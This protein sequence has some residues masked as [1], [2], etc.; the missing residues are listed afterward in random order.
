LITSL[1]QALSRLPRADQIQT[2]AD[3]TVAAITPTLACAVQTTLG[4]PELCLQGRV[5]WAAVDAIGETATLHMDGSVTGSGA[6]VEVPHCE[7]IAF[8]KWPDGPTGMDGDLARAVLDVSPFGTP[9]VH[10]QSVVAMNARGAA[11]VRRGTA[12]PTGWACPVAL[13]K[14]AALAS[15]V[16]WARGAARGPGWMAVA[17]IPV[18][19]PVPELEAPPPVAWID[20][21]L[22]ARAVALVVAT[23][24]VDEPIVT[25]TNRRLF[26]PWASIEIDTIGDV[27]NVTVGAKAMAMGLRSLDAGPCGLS[28]DRS[29]LYLCSDRFLCLAARVYP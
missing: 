18:A 29:G 8:P 26:T 13:A 15:S 25:I 4:L 14:V 22:L 16:E 17:R 2:Y 10:P 23:A 28:Q 6:K 12:A 5:L 11:M 24:P 7:A 9:F 19:A 27:I 20:S 1:S 21:A 3:G